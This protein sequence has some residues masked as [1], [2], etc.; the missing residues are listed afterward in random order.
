MWALGCILYE[1]TTRK[2]A[3]TGQNLPA[4]V[5]KILSGTY[6]RP[7]K[8][9]SRRLINLI[10]SMLQKDPTKRPAVDEVLSSNFVL[11]YDAPSTEP[12]PS[13][14]RR[15]QELKDG[16]EGGQ[17]AERPP[18]Y[19]IK[20]KDTQGDMQMRGMKEWI[21]KQDKQRQQIRE[22]LKA[23]RRV[24]PSPMSTLRSPEKVMAAPSQTG[25]DKSGNDAKGSTLVNRRR[26]DGISRDAARKG[27]SRASVGVASD[28]RSRLG[29]TV[30]RDN[31]RRR[32][33]SSRDTTGSGGD[34]ERTE[35]PKSDDEGDDERTSLDDGDVLRRKDVNDGRPRRRQ[36][37]KDEAKDFKLKAM[38]REQ[39]DL[40][41]QHVQKQ[42][43]KERIV[44]TPSI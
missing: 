2:R 36:W 20:A 22:A 28:A 18:R 44:E 10:D 29:S 7:P 6:P 4:L 11:G 40:T 5:F 13:T 1:M 25:V 32:R 31:Q 23:K 12:S 35:G 24:L 39:A 9:Y 33:S 34:D 8:K 16:V 42:G 38:T 3:F 21:K 30:S 41:V 19:R 17:M 14:P 26:S 43:M 15:E 27:R 37:N